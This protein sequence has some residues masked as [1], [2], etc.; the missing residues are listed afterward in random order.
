MIIVSAPP[1]LTNEVVDHPFECDGQLVQLVGTPS[2][3][4]SGHDLIGG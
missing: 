1:G 3:K 2:G 4:C